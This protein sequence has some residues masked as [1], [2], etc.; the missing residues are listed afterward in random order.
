MMIT[1]MVMTT[2]MTTQMRKMTTQMRKMTTQ[3][4]KTTM[5]IT[6]VKRLSMTRTAGYLHLHSRL[7]QTL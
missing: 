7:K 4:R 1:T 2:M 5:M 6:P 3:M